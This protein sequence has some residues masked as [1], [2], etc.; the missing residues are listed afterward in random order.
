MFLGT[1]NELKN[2][3]KTN[4]VNRSYNQFDSELE[5]PIDLDFELNGLDVKSQFNLDIAKL[6]ATTPI[7]IFKGLVETT[8][9]NIAAATK[10]RKIAES[11]GA[12]KLPIIPYSLGLLPAG[13]F[14]PP[15]GI[16]PPILPPYGYMYWAIDAGE[17]LYAY[18]NDKNVNNRNKLT[19]KQLEDNQGLSSLSDLLPEECK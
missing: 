13:L 3:I 12:Q 9:P 19:T 6:V 4:L 16:G 2:I 17:V 8:D 15:V 7:K 18:S 11:A 5:C 1:F 14:P 10:I